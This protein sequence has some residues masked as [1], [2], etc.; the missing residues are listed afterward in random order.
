MTPFMSYRT[1]VFNSNGCLHFTGHLFQPFTSPSTKKF[2]LISKLNI[3]CNNLRPFP[4]FLI[5]FYLGEEAEPHLATTPCQAVVQTDKVPPEPPFLQD[6][7]PQHPQQLL[8]GLALQ[9]LPQLN[10]PSLDSL[11]ALSV[12]L[13]P[14]AQNWTW[15]LGCGLIS[16][17]YRGTIRQCLILLAT[18]FLTQIIWANI[19]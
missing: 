15:H 12:F 4:L 2:F 8:T 6:K 11:Q 3:P 1:D 18:L 16:A 14:R 7:H 5:P 13:V 9:T 19:L 10:C 17:K